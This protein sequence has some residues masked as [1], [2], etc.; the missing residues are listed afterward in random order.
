M[1]AP[2]LP[3]PFAELE[4]FAATWVLASGEDRYQRRLSSTMD[5]LQDFYDAVFPRAEEAIA[6]LEQFELDAL[7][8]DAVNLLRMLYSLSTVSPSVDVF[9][10]QKVPESGTTSM[11]WLDEPAI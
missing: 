9:A 4:P 1:T 11:T 10:Q 3:E 8:D 7:P 2:M 6:Y 5:E